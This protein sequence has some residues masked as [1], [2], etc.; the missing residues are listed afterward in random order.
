MGIYV[1]Q[2]FAKV[3]VKLFHHFLCT[4][5]VLF[6]SSLWTPCLRRYHKL[7]GVLTH[8][9]WLNLHQSR[10][11][12]SLGSSQ[13]IVWFRHVSTYAYEPRSLTL[14]LFSK[15][16]RTVFPFGSIVPQQLHKLDPTQDRPLCCWCSMARYLSIADDIIRQVSSNLICMLWW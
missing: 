2:C 16:N 15:W 4:V 11:W 8:W 5:C 14:S 3:V 10:L 6:N 13:W 7:H 1:L 9:V 12:S